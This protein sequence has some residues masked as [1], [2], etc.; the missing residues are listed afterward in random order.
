MASY[1]QVEALRMKLSEGNMLHTMVDY[2]LQTIGDW[3]YLGIFVLMFLEST[4][5]P[6][7]SELVIPPAAMLAHPD[8]AASLGRE[9]L[10]IYGVV[11]AGAFGSLGGATFNY[12][13]ALWLGKPFLERYGK[14]FLLPPHKL[15]KVEAFFLRHGEIGTFTGRLILGVRHFISMPAGLAQMHLGRFA[16]LTTLGAALWCA[17]LAVIGWYAGDIYAELGPQGVQ[18]YFK[19]YGK[20]AAYAALAGS[21]VLLA[22]YALWQRNRKTA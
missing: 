21:A 13:L 18:D 19:A 15:A 16:I 12:Y 7:P 22:I 6:I 3:G 17:I 4:L 5:F 10:N 8:L 1:N 2:F 14:W 20:Q 9:P 11:L